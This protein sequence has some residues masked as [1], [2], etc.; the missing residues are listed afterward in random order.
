MIVAAVLSGNRNFEGRIHPQVRAN[1]LASPPLVVA[2]AL[3]GRMD[4][5]LTTEPLG[6]DRDGNPVYLRDVWP[7]N[8][9]IDARDRRVAS[10]KHRFAHGMPTC[11]RATTIGARSRC[12]KANAMRGIRERVRQE[13]AVLRG[14]ARRA[15]PARRHRGSAR[16]RGARRQRDDRPH[17]ARRL[18]RENEPGRGISRRTRRRSG[19]LQ[20]VRRAARQ[21][22]S[23]GARNVR[24]RALAQ[25][26]RS[27]RRRR[28]HAL[29]SRRTRRCR[30]SMRPS[31][32]APTARR[33]SSSPAK[34]TD[35]VRR[36]IGRRRDRCC[37]AFAPSSPNRS[38][39]SIAAI[40]IGMGILPLEYRAG[41]KP[42]VARPH[43]RGDVRYRRSRATASCRAAV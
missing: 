1:Y 12:P 28:R 36:A 38:S 8:A 37:S 39:A 11:S 15:G 17:L 18:H 26:A 42:R 30:S 21:S 2:Y 40:S 20:L 23:D 31:A 5:D 32:T 16:A 27:G 29:S 13:T 4:L 41:R 25:R 34:N 10:P 6:T 33:S 14:H 9:E 43:R 22:R 35:R 19:G 24:Q 3:A 7:S